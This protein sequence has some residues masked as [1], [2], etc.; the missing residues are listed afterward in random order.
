ML[1]M[2]PQSNIGSWE[3]PRPGT[4][5]PRPRASS[6]NERLFGPV[7]EKKLL[8][9]LRGM[10]EGDL[11]V[12]CVGIGSALFALSQFVFFEV[13]CLGEEPE[14]IDEVRRTVSILDN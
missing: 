6:A 10:Y 11:T 3:I 9:A 5:P 12:G 4:A 13:L 7:V 8:A 1:W 2:P 14:Q